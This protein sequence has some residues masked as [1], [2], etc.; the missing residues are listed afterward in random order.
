M[1]VFSKEEKIDALRDAQEKLFE[2]IETLESVFPDDGNVHAYMIDHL[3]IKA[4][5]GHG[6]LSS[7]LN[8]DELI[9]RVQDDEEE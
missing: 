5:S 3:K 1:F 7:D 6:F 4:S 9:E 2:V 8:F